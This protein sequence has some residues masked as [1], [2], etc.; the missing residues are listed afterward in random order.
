MSLYLTPHATAV[1]DALAVARATG[2][3]DRRDD[4]RRG[5]RF[6][7]HQ[8]GPHL[9]RGAAVR[10]SGPGVH[11]LP[12]QRPLRRRLGVHQAD[13]RR[14]GRRD[15]RPPRHVRSPP[16]AASA[17]RSRT[18]RSTA[19]SSPTSTRIDSKLHSPVAASTDDGYVLFLSR[20]TK[21]K[22]VDDL[23]DGYAA[24]HA[25]DQVPLVIAAPAPR[26][27]RCEPAPRRRQ[28]PTGSCS[29]TMS[30]TTRRRS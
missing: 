3:P 16:S 26:H 7:H 29:S 9:G 6:R 2:L 14:V 8:R 11:H 4:D 17:S 30:T 19:A 20:V 28:P 5:G 15:R 22:G 18:R 27:R 13:H 21:A 23:I 24:S 12:R 25:S 1:N 10:R